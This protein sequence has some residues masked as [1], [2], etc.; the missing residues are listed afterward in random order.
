MLKPPACGLAMTALANTGLHCA[1][2]PAAFRTS[3]FSL[4]RGGSVSGFSR[5]WFKPSFPDPPHLKRLLSHLYLKGPSS[6]SLAL[7]FSSLVGCLT[8]WLPSHPEDPLSQF[9]LT[10]SRN[11]DIGPNDLRD[12][13]H[14]L[15]WEPA[16][17]RDD[18]FQAARYTALHVPGGQSKWAQPQVGVRF[19][20]CEEWMVV[21][22]PQLVA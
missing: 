10:A 8:N 15:S 17:Q 2:K 4:R 20:P 3:P 12:T 22:N 7:L 18:G 9:C 13:R 11:R 14:Q 1:S 21:P 6:S 5:R 19:P 16:G